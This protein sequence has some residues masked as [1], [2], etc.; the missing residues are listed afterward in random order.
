MRLE[1][2]EPRRKL[3]KLGVAPGVL[4]SF[5]AEPDHLRRDTA[6]TAKKRDDEICLGGGGI[7]NWRGRF[8]GGIVRR[9]QGKRLEMRGEGGAQK[10]KW[11]KDHGGVAVH[12]I[13]QEAAFGQ[14]F[15]G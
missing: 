3:R 2:R 1:K 14:F 9:N 4:K 12:G 13:S 6:E 5:G 15:E 11:Q 7:G 8:N 10:K